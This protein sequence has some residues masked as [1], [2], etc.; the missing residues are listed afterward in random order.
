MIKE[1]DRL[2][3]FHLFAYGT[4]RTDQP[5]SKMFADKL[6][7]SIPA[8]LQGRLYVLPEGYPILEVSSNQIIAHATADPF[9]DWD[10]AIKAN[11]HNGPRV[12]TCQDWVEGELLTLPL[13]QHVFDSMDAWEGFSLNK[14]TLYQRIITQAYDTHGK[15]YYCWTY[16][17]ASSPSLPIRR[18]NSSHW[19]RPDWL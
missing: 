18:L 6:I 12:N 15:R 14:D 16:T 13:E 9:H 8:K 5:E 10:A 19:K 2:T 3:G 11:E 17:C 4:L 7:S 1:N